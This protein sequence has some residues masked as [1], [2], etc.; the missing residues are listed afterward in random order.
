MSAAVGSDATEGPLSGVASGKGS[1]RLAG[2]RAAS[3]PLP[4]DDASLIIRKVKHGALKEAS[5]GSVNAV[6]AQRACLRNCS[7]KPMTWATAL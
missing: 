7:T 4:V 2:E 1:S 3:P 5:R 6:T